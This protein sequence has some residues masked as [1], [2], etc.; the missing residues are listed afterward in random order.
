MSEENLSPLSKS[1][2]KV[3]EEVAVKDDQQRQQIAQ[4][5]GLPGESTWGQ[6]GS[7]AIRKTVI[8]QKKIVEGVSRVNPNLAEMLGRCYED[9]LPL[10]QYMSAKPENPIAKLAAAT[11]LHDYA[12]LRDQMSQ[13]TD[14]AI[15]ATNGITG[16]KQQ[17]FTGWS[18]GI[19]R[20]L[21]K[22]Y[23]EYGELQN[24]VNRG[25]YNL[26]EDEIM[27]NLHK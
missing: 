20:N 5:Q 27:E 22:S 1:I 2:L 6:I 21:W 10:L 13:I 11:F 7:E 26:D 17:L 9:G 23:K 18:H 25:G 19:L 4:E 8:D 3:L 16:K 15:L 12:A 24:L 14:P